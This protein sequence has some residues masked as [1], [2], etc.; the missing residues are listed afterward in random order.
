M[1]NCEAQFVPTIAELQ[2][3]RRTG[4]TD[5]MKSS[6]PVVPVKNPH[7][8]EV[9]GYGVAER[10]EVSKAAHDLNAIFD[11]SPLLPDWSPDV[12]EVEKSVTV[13]DEDDAILFGTFPTCLQ[14]R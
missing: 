6:A 3:F 9:I 14:P 13:A 10:V 11:D 1:K 7:T 8:G 12:V 4:K 2:E 5:V